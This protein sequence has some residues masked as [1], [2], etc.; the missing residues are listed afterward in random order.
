MALKT[1]GEVQVSQICQYNT[2]RQVTQVRFTCSNEQHMSS[3][4]FVISHASLKKSKTRKHS[5]G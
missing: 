4:V 1:E 2:G 5:L 3:M